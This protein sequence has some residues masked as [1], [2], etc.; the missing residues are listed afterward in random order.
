[1]YKVPRTCYNMYKILLKNG[2]NLNNNK[3][4]YTCKIEI[5]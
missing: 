1:M 4:E 2:V 5:Y 3:A